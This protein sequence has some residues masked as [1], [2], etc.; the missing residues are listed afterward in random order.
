MPLS[1]DANVIET[2]NGLVDALRGAAG[3]APKSFRPGTLSPVSP[4]QAHKATITVPC[5]VSI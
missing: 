3:G 5:H 4:T 1:E 2:S